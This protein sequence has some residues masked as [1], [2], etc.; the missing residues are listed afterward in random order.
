M[1]PQQLIKALYLNTS[2]NIEDIDDTISTVTLKI[3]LQKSLEIGLHIQKSNT[4]FLPNFS[5]QHNATTKLTMA[6]I[7][8][9]ETH[10]KQASS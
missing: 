9:L 2:T 10:S 6:K 3:F 8:K 5:T 7:V 4:Q 1:I